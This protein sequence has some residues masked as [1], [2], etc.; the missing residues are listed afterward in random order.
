M[1]D[2]V[3]LHAAALLPLLAPRPLGPL[4]PLGPRGPRRPLAAPGPLLPRHPVQPRHPGVALGTLGAGGP[5][6]GRQVALDDGHGRLV[7]VQLGLQNLNLE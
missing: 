6:Q 4:L 7:A 1:C 5:L 2:L 3:D